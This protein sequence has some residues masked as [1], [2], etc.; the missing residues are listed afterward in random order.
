MNEGSLGSRPHLAALSLQS[1]HTLLAPLGPHCTGTL[2]RSLSFA[3]IKSGKEGT[4]IR[5]ISG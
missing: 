1:A 5:S 4:R 3:I 2:R